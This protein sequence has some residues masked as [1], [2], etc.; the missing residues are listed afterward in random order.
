[1]KIMV[2]SKDGPSLGNCGCQNWASEAGCGKA[3]CP[4]VAN[5]TTCNTRV[6]RIARLDN[7][8]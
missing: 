7:C 6:E 4:E 1:M 3:T 8:Q 2:R 5:S